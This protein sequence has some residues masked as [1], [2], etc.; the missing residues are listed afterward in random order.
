VPLHNHAPYIEERLESLFAQWQPQLELLLV[1]DA[2]TDEGFAIAEQTLARHPEIEATSVRNST[3]LGI[4]VLS[5]LLGLARGTIIIQA[6]SDDVALPGRLHDTL[7]CFDLDPT[8][9]LVTSNALLLSAEGFPAG[10]VSTSEPDEVFTDPLRAA[11]RDGDMRWLG[12]TSAFH[13]SVFDSL[14]PID[15][16]ECPYGLDLLLPFRALLL[17]SHHYLSRPLVGWRLHGRNTHRMVGAQSASLADQ[18]RYQAL[19][20]MVLRQKLRDAE[21]YQRHPDA[22]PPPDGLVEACM[23]QFLSKFDLWSRV[24]TAADRVSFAARPQQDRAAF[25]G[26]PAIATLNVGQRISFD[27]PFAAALV[28]GWPG[29]YAAEGWGIWTHRQA[30][31]CFRV[32]SVDV[33]SIRIAIAGLPFL[34]HQRVTVSIDLEYRIALELIGDERREVTLPVGGPG[35]YSILIQADNA[36]SPPSSDPRELGVGL[37][38]VEAASRETKCSQI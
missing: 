4:G 14:P 25:L 16:A 31:I 36:A 9:R 8:C 18:D 20:M 33:V 19:E 38:W 15:P 28:V 22:K 13:R 23:H 34:G 6:D 30:L 32:R 7:A 26:V 2:S 1:D 21:H 17:G 29:F 37:Y 24:R 35:L 27:S 12:A 3:T 5:V 10:L 11:A